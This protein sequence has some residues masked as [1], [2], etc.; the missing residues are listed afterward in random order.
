MAFIY[1]N[2]RKVKNP[3]MWGSLEYKDSGLWPLNVLF[4]VS[5]N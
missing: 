2:L 5:A 4:W 1:F 3:V